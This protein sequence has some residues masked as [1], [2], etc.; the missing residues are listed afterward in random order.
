MR[1]QRAKHAPVP[2]VSSY[3]GRGLR[4]AAPWLAVIPALPGLALILIRPLGMRF[5]GFLLVALAAVLLVGGFLRQWAGRSRAGWWCHLAFRAALALVLVPLVMIEACVIHEG[6]KEPPQQ[7]ADAV[8]VLGAG[9]NGK[10][11]SLS[12][13]TRLDAAIAYLETDP[14]VPVVLTGG[15][16]YGEDIT[17]AQ[18]M[19]DYLTDHGVDGD[20]LILEEA[21]STTAENFAFSRG[22]LTEAGVDP[23][24][25]TVAVVTNDFHIA[26]AK[27]L[28]ARNGYGHAVGVPAELPWVHLQ[29][30]Y[31][32]R[33]AF[34][35]VKS[36]LLD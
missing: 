19:Y 33:E 10:E 2:V 26:R 29:I 21:A 12:L 17:E 1:R 23:S 14:D 30:N 4:R 31:Y 15:Q 36:F 16:G 6:G 20:R 7:P 32:L 24:R 3:R 11:P 25:A 18:C 13:K 5:S 22:L 34:A 28:A 35:M 27:L 8:I 9:V